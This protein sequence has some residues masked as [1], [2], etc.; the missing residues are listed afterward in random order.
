MA[1]LLLRVQDANRVAVDKRGD[2]CSGCAIVIAKYAL[3]VDARQH[4]CFVK[5]DVEFTVDAF[6]G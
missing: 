6:Q 5:S 3:V 1:C 4:K 2:V